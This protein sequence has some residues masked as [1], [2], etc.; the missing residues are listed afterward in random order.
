[1]TLTITRRSRDGGYDVRLQNTTAGNAELSVV[2]C[3]RYTKNVGVK[4]L[5]A[6]LGVVE[7]DGATRGLLVTT[8]GFTRCAR[9]E[10]S[11]TNRIE[12]IDY[13]TLCTL[14]NEHFGPEWLARI[15]GIIGHAQRQFGEKLLDSTNLSLDTRSQ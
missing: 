15:D 9:A 12:L 3:K 4:E 6:L 2:E 5:R 14:F 11:Q 13:D 1:M 10:A 7:R 8:S